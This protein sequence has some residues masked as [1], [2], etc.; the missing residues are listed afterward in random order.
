MTKT[1]QVIRGVDI[2][3]YFIWQKNTKLPFL[4][5]KWLRSQFF[6]SSD[7]LNC[8]SEMSGFAIFCLIL[9]VSNLHLVKC[10]PKAKVIKIENNHTIFR[11]NKGLWSLHLKSLNVQ[12]TKYVSDNNYAKPSRPAFV[13]Q[14]AWEIWRYKSMT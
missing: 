12:S 14:V 2:V 9:F 10:V 13:F 1:K 11:F 4:R 3:T 8:F 5:Q 7:F 6:L